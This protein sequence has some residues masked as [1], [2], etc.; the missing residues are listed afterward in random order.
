MKNQR[1]IGFE[2]PCKQI[3][4]RTSKFYASNPKNKTNFLENPNK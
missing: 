2:E 4:A 1:N 3:D